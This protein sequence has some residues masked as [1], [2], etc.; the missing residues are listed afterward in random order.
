MNNGDEVKKLASLARISVEDSELAKFG[1]EFESILAYIGQIEKLEV[2]T[3][4][5]PNPLHKNVFREDGTPHEKGLYTKNIVDAFSQK[6]GNYL[7]VKKIISH[8]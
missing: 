3:G 4:V 1:K 7:K 8:D 2:D 6:D 5:S